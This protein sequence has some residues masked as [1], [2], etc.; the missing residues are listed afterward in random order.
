MEFQDWWTKQYRVINKRNKALCVMCSDSVVERHQLN[1]P[2]K[3]VTNSFLTKRRLVQNKS[4]YR[5]SEKMQL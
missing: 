3:V 1:I 5:A 2:M 4:I